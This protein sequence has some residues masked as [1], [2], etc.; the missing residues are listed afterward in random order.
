M[1]LYPNYMRQRY[2]NAKVSMAGI[3]S[4]Y[5]F[6]Y[7][8]EGVN[9]TQSY[10]VDFR[11][12]AMK[13][14]VG[15]WNAYLDP[16]C[17]QGLGSMGFSCIFANYSYKFVDPEVRIFAAQAQSDRVVLEDHDNIPDKYVSLAPEQAYLVEW[18]NNMTIA[19]SQ[20]T[21]AGHGIFNPAC[22]I[23]TEFSPTAPLIQGLSWLEAFENH[24]F[25]LTGPAGFQLAD[26]CGIM[27]NP[28]CP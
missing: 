18:R 22:L 11:E 6:A 12:S 19:L 16:T 26:N 2:P 25:N 8:Y 14:T 15:L 28:T 4:F 20:L 23:H 5:F 1:W 24:Y 27:C 7:P 3:A 13:A 21:Q 10:L 9:H 17:T